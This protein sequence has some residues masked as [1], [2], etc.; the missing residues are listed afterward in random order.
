MNLGIAGKPVE[1]LLKRM[2]RIVENINKPD[3]IFIM[4][5]I[6]NTTAGD[7]D[8]TKTYSRS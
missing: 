3:F 1:G 4:N 8:I 5:G 2:G 7:F 6:N